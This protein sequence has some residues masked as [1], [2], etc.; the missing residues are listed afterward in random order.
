MGGSSPISPMSSKNS[1]TDDSPVYM[2]PSQPAA[3]KL[4]HETSSRV[5]SE[6]LDGKVRGVRN[7]E[8]AYKLYDRI[9]KW[10]LFVG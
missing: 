8:A 4:G 2:P 6:S 10:F 5:D 7:A 3:E 1:P 9:S